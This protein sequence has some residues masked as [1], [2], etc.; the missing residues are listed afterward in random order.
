MQQELHRQADNV[1]TYRRALSAHAMGS[2]GVDLGRVWS[3]T[4][5]GLDDSDLEVTDVP[6]GGLWH[7]IDWEDDWQL[8]VDTFDDIF[9]AR[10]QVEDDDF[11]FVDVFFGEPG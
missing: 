6:T 9:D 4:E 10:G 1:R 2:R 8:F 3:T 7:G 5:E 11:Q